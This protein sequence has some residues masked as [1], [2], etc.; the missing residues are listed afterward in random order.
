MWYGIWDRLFGCVVVMSN[1]GL[2]SKRM[3]VG[4]MYVGEVWIDVMGWNDVK[5]KIGDDGFGEFVCG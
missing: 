4:E 1:V 2:G 5:I 3:Y